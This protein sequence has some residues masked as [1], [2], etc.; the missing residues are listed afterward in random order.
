MILLQNPTRGSPIEINLT[1]RFGVQVLWVLRHFGPSITTKSPHIM[2][3]VVHSRIPL[4]SS[5]EFHR[6]LS[7]HQFSS[8][9]IL[10]QSAQSF[11][12][13]VAS[14][15]TFT[16]MTQLEICDKFSSEYSISFNPDKYQLLHYT[17][18]S[19]I[20]GMFFN[21]I[22]IKS[23]K[24]ANHLGITLNIDNK[25]SCVKNITDMFYVNVNSLKATFPNVSREIKYKLFKT[26]CMSVY[27]SS[28]WDYSSK[29]VNTFL[30]AWRKSIRYL[31]QLP[32]K[33]RYIYL[34]LICNDLPVDVQ[35]HSRFLNFFQKMVHKTE[36]QLIKL[37]CDIALQGSRSSVCNTLN[38]LVYRYRIDKYNINYGTFNQ[39]VIKT[40]SEMY[41]EDVL[42]RY[43][44]LV[45]FIS[46]IET[47]QIP[48]KNDLY[49]I[50]EF[51]STV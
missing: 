36:N 24:S 7:L 8:L 51:V 15:T 28:L 38:L 16:P 20:E 44:I 11:I 19:V 12:P 50:I 46:L 45:D 43:G 39:S 5:M 26:F 34:P 33:C 23:A 48:F 10:T 2:G 13:T 37:C 21:G 47:N 6:A 29:T 18:S 3:Y 27:G 49:D 41:N 32:Y 42:V 31:L 4:R 17:Q 14:T 9:S 25:G 22:F 40:M 35:L 30:T 1:A